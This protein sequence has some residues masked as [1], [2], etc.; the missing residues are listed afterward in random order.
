MGG[1]VGGWLAWWLAGESGIK[2]NLSLS[3]SLSLFEAELGKNTCYRREMYQS[4]LE[5]SNDV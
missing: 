5:L 2:D 4:P 1:W 3:L